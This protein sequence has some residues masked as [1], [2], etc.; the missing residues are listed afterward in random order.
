MT[1]V[2][3]FEFKKCLN[4]YKVCQRG[5]MHT[6]ALLQKAI[7]AYYSHDCDS[8]SLFSTLFLSL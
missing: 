3:K 1:M 4:A 5:M 6:P 2:A 8:Q 7:S